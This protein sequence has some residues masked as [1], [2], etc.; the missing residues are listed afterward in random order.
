VGL[1]HLAVLA[2]MAA[3]GGRWW[4]AWFTVLPI[5]AVA[6]THSHPADWN[7]DGFCF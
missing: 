1:G 5:A 4:S 3:D 2:A 7:G 6:V